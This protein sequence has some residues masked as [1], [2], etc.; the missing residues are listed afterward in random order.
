MGGGDDEGGGAGRGKNLWP[1]SFPRPSSLGPQPLLPQTQ[2]SGLRL[3]SD[4]RVWAHSPSQQ[5]ETE[6]SSPQTSLVQAPSP[7]SCSA[8]LCGSPP[9]PSFRVV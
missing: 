1:P 7:P 5:L 9:P 4:P 8:Q 3:P 6:A 2:D